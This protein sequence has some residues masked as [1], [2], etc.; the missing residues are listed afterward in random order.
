MA[1]NFRFDSER[2]L[3]VPSERKDV[4][5]EPAAKTVEK[6][7]EEY[8]EEYEIKKSYEALAEEKDI[9]EFLQEVDNSICARAEELKIEG[10]QEIE[11]FRQKVFWLAKLD[12]KNLDDQKFAQYLDSI[13][14]TNGDL[15]FIK[16]TID[17]TLDEIYLSRKGK[18]TTDSRFPKV[19]AAIEFV[20]EHKKVLNLGVL[21]L[22]LSTF[23][24]G[25]L[26]ALSGDGAKIIMDSDGIKE[27]A[28]DSTDNADTLNS[29]SGVRGENI[30]QALD[31]LEEF[32]KD[33]R[34]D[35]EDKDSI[36]LITTQQLMEHPELIALIDKNKDLNSPVNVLEQI[37]NA[38][39][40]VD[41]D[42]RFSLLVKGETVYIEDFSAD[43]TSGIEETFCKN[44]LSFYDLIGSC[45]GSLKLFLENKDTIARAIADSTGAS[46]KKLES[47]F[48]RV[49]L[50]E[51]S[52]IDVVRFEDF[53]VPVDKDTPEITKLKNAKKEIYK[54]HGLDA[55]G[56]LII[57][58]SLQKQI[59][60]IVTN[61]DGLVDLKTQEARDSFIKINEKQRGLDADGELKIWL[62][63]NGYGV[64]DYNQAMEQAV[65][66]ADNCRLGQKISGL[67]MNVVHTDSYN[68]S[69]EFKDMFIKDLKKEGYSLADLETIDPKKRIEIVA[70][71][72]VNNM[73]Y[74]EVEAKNI[75]ISNHPEITKLGIKHK[76][77]PAA[78]LGTR[79]GICHDYAITMAAG[80]D[81]LNKMGIFGDN[82]A[83]WATT[84]QNEHMY[85]LLAT[86]K[87][88]H[89]QF[90]MVDPTF[91][92]EGANSTG[93]DEFNVT[94]FDAIN[95]DHGYHGVSK[96]VYEE[97]KRKFEEREEEISQEIE[98]THREALQRIEKYNSFV[99][100]QKIIDM[101]TTYDPK[102]IQPRKI[103][104]DEVSYQAIKRNEME[105]E[106]EIESLKKQI[107]E[108]PRWF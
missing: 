19:K 15:D 2:N 95:E 27:D 40:F 26:K 89:I 99:S 75:I 83:V 66:E 93:E 101:I 8:D 60:E 37:G 104:V 54:E 103:A 84:K 90:S 107:Q 71:T 58:E 16:G 35:P 6:D 44:N 96:G 20:G 30:S 87:D 28:K 59:D 57:D 73:D 63:D 79:A 5:K 105:V 56:Q 42:V 29:M 21:A 10:D 102:A 7:I 62:E 82:L 47:Y 43:N 65:T 32:E 91:A 45:G 17:D 77:I 80:I 86:Y 64:G 106:M 55:F 13:H 24:S 98:K 85:L 4:A 69:E 67:G 3:I 46:E 33:R 108:L 18:I 34:L 50:P 78:T 52:Q 88:G 51:T 36:G 25:V 1:E 23:G 92:D 11:F 53:Q 72:V 12:F 74:D 97:E 14:V 31:V 38:G 94:N 70:R 61:D 68:Y 22:Y 76:S 48:E 49:L 41:G 39:E 81:V 100:Q 9:K